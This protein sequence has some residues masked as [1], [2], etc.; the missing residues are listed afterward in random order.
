MIGKVTRGTKIG[1]LLRYL[2]GP[3]RFNEHQE[4][5]LVAAWDEGLPALEP[6]STLASDYRRFDM[7]ALTAL[8]G[9][10]VAALGTQAPAKPVLQVSLRT[11]PRDR[12]LSDQD[13]GEIAR[14]VM[15][16]LGLAA[17]GD[18]NGV[19]WVAVRHAEDHVHLAA[20]MARQDGRSAKDFRLYVRLREAA[21]AAEAKFGLQVTA[22]A[23]KTAA[24]RPSRAET[25]K[26]VRA[27]AGESVRET[28]RRQVRVAAGGALT[29][30]DFWYR[31]DAAGVTV[32]RR[33]SE[34]NPG[35]ITGYAVGLSKADLAAVKAG[36]T[37]DHQVLLFS[38]GK[39]APDL[40]LPKLRAR[41]SPVDNPVGDWR[42]LTGAERR[43][44]WEEVI[45]LAAAGAEHV[46]EHV[47]NGRYDEA[48]DAAWATSD[49]IGMAATVLDHDELGPMRSAADNYD[50]AARET[51]RQRPGRSD[52]GTQ[53]RLAAVMLG[54]LARTDVSDAAAV[55]LL[56]MHLTQLVEA[57]AELREAQGRAVQATAAHAAA[58]I[59]AAEHGGYRR[60]SET[61]A[62]KFGVR[63]QH[64]P[65]DTTRQPVAK[66][67]PARR[68][69]NRLERGI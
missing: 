58:E 20:T 30:S 46:R 44:A 54:L 49:V 28:L 35:E 56:T 60:L 3:G 25:E 61:I 32:K 22:S 24:S 17:P 36:M 39:L 52:A 27:G 51:F 45:A 47:A 19:R 14:D 16:H 9:A 11:A 57:V 66:E 55:A 69:P 5:H 15:A 64:L 33:Y 65:T 38:G 67:S 12:H 6:P 50:R 59:V 41:W 34:R 26:A 4:P 48:S 2:Y 1:G 8:L 23:D 10:P 29:E 68:R 13:W 37:G 43:Q 53:L 42:A 31:L 40:S 62:S 21:N 18:P 63:A 7:R